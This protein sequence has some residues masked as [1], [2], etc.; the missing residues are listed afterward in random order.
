MSEMYFWP[1]IGVA[2][3]WFL[4]GLSSAYGKRYESKI[5]IGQ[6]LTL[7]LRLYENLAQVLDELERYKDDVNSWEEFEIIR[8]RAMEKHFD[9]ENVILEGIEKSFSDMSGIDP[10]LA[11]KILGIKRG[12]CETKVVSMSTLSK[13]QDIYVKFLSAQETTLILIREMI[14]RLIRKLSFKYSV[15]TYFKVIKRIGEIKK[16]DPNHNTFDLPRISD[17]KKTFENKKSI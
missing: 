16:Y 5:K 8:K 14:E 3:G 1:L 7:L 12:L 6:G 10:V 4:N 15:F 9:S 11:L 17:L 2:L 13:D